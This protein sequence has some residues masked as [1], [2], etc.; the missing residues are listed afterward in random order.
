MPKGVYP[1]TEYHRKILSESAKKRGIKPPS[2]KGIPHTD[3]T[4]RKMS[5]NRKGWI[6]PHWLDDQRKKEVAKKISQAK[7]GKIP[8]NKGRR[9]IYRLSEETKRKISEKMKVAMKGKHTSPATEFKKGHKPY[10]TFKENPKYHQHDK[11]A[12]HPITIR[13]FDIH[14]LPEYR[15]K[16]SLSVIKLWQDPEY[17]KK[18]TGPNHHWWKGGITKRQEALARALRVELRKWAKAVLE[19]DNYICQEC[20]QRFEK[21]FLHAHHIKSIS[22][23]PSLVLDISNGITLC[24][25]CHSETESYGRKLR[26]TN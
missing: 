5:L 14:K 16:V 4:K 12:W 20:G 22:K 3:E 17:R 15:K 10:K 2:R 23:Y 26:K 24:K 6:P 19:R 7:K 21:V 8:W 13:H 11:Y 18:R 25:K 1:K 9:G